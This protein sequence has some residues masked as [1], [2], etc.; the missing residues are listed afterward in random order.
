LRAA[1][2]GVIALLEKRLG[3]KINF[4]NLAY[5]LSRKNDGFNDHVYHAIHHDHTIKTPRS[6]H[7][8]SQKPLKNT[9]THHANFFLRL[10]WKNPGDPLQLQIRIQL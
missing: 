9:S 5:F 6:A 2:L 8:F 10:T 3:S 7:R 1:A 4:E